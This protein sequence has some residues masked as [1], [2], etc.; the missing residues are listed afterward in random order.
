[1]PAN[2][3]IENKNTKQKKKVQIW[4]LVLGIE[5]CEISKNF[6]IRV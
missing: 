1:M 5:I 4:F 6:V 3:T 2:T